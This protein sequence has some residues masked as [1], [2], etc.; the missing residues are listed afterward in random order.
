MRPRVVMVGLALATTLSITGCPM[1]SK[2][3]Q[4]APTRPIVDV[5]RDHT[6][7]IM[8]IPGV[9]GL[10]EGVLNDG[11]PC[12]KVM[13]ERTT[14]ELEQRIPKNLE[15]YPVA[16]HETGVIRPLSPDSG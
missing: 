8:A 10:Y 2:T 7:E 15:G 5:L 1:E 14:R 4:P 12:I 3:P 13:V 9:V 11:T 6:A 16:I